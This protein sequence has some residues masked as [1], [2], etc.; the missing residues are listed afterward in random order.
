MTVS[1]SIVISE[2][3][4]VLGSGHYINALVGPLDEALADFR[5]KFSLTDQDS[6]GALD[7]ERPEPTIYAWPSDLLGVFTLVMEAS[8]TYV[9]KKVFDEVWDITLRPKV[10]SAVTT[11]FDRSAGRKY[12]L[13]VLFRAEGTGVSILIASVG[14]SIEEIEQGDRQA[15]LIIARAVNELA[16]LGPSTVTGVGSI[17]MYVIENGQVNELPWI[18]GNVHEALLAL[19]RMSPARNPNLVR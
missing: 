15:R 1:N 3:F 9:A 17:H 16:G 5:E 6:S 13:S 7:L 12:G 8:G 18:Y 4:Y 14:K 2:N 19:K 11:L 10:R